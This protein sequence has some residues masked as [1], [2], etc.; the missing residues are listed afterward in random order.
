VIAA[1]IAG[2]ITLALMLSQMG[3][4]NPHREPML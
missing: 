3:R 2:V 1:L 4:D